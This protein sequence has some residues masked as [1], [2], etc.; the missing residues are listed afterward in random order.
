MK[1]IV[2]GATGFIGSH[3]VRALVSEGMDVRILR[4]SSSPTL[5]LQGLRPGKDIEEVIDP[6]RKVA[7]M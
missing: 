5:A 4:R 7:W 3:V 1:A 6:T 2:F